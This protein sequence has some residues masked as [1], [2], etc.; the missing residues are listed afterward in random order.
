[1]DL[2][3]IVVVWGRAGTYSHET[4]SSCLSLHNVGFSLAMKGPQGAFQPVS[5][6]SG[7]VGVPLGGE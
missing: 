7:L 3:G 1:M 6:L 2:I 5:L 4:V